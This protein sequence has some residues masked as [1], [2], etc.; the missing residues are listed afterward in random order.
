LSIT[1]NDSFDT[2]VQIF[3]ALGFKKGVLCI[4]NSVVY[5]YEGIEFALVEVPGHSY[6]FEAELL[7]SDTK[8]KDRAHEK[9]EAVC[10]KLGMTIF[11][12][13]EYFDY[14]KQLNR[15][16]NILF[17]FSEYTEGYFKKTFNLKK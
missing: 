15:E 5:T 16:T 14:V 1:S 13:N 4:R 3:G 9:I 6:Y 17:D 10:T 2:L 7:I 8:D 11:S 12:N